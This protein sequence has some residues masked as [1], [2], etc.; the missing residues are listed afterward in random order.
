MFHLELVDR[1]DN[2]FLLGKFI[3]LTQI[4]NIYFRING[5]EHE[6]CQALPY[7]LEINLVKYD[8]GPFLCC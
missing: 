5:F 8:K 4:S 1:E 3:F 6:S 2:F 7:L